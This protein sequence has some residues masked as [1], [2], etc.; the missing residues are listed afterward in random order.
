MQGGIERKKY[1]ISVSEFEFQESPSSGTVN[2][3]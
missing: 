2:E 3:T 1:I